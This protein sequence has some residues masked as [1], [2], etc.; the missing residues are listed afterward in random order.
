MPEATHTTT[1]VLAH[2]QRHCDAH[3]AAERAA[4]QAA[5]DAMTQTG[6]WVLPG[7]DGRGQVSR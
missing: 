2:L 3:A 1:A 4:E 6:D 5:H 7:A